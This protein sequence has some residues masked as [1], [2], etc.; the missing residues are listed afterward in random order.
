MRTRSKDNTESKQRE[1]KGEKA[2][3]S[4]KMTKEIQDKSFKKSKKLTWKEVVDSIYHNQDV[5]S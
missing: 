4:R 2:R 5:L 1:I 3:K